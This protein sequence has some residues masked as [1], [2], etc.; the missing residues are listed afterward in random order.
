MLLHQ[1]CTVY[2]L[3]NI[4]MKV[5]NPNVGC[6]DW[7]GGKKLPI[8]ERENILNNN[9]FYITLENEQ[10]HSKKVV[11]SSCGENWELGEVHIERK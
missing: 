7:G 10:D 5:V 4:L 1:W 8:I 2:I 6:C 3:I 9:C 11:C